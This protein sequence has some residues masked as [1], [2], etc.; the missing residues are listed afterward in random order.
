MIVSAGLSVVKE[1][2]SSLVDKSMTVNPT[3]H[4]DAHG[5]AGPTQPSVGERAGESER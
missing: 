5:A 1:L 2:R 4:P 3:P